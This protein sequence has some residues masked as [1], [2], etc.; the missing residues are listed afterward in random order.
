MK[1][2]QEKLKL[3]PSPIREMIKQATYKRGKKPFYLWQSFDWNNN[4]VLND[5]NFWSGVDDEIEYHAE[6]FN[7]KK[8]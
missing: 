5:Q 7:K 2:L 6:Q 3:V 4:K 8:K 1:T